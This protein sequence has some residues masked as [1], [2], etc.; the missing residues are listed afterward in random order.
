MRELC[1]TSGEMEFDGLLTGLTPANQ[2]S[3]GTIA[4]TG[5]E[6]TYVRGTV[7]AKSSNDNMLYI[8]GTEPAEDDD[9]DPIE[10]LTPD[11]ILCD[12]ITVGA[13]GDETVAVYTAGCFDPNKVTL[14][15]SYDMTESDK[16]ELRMRN[17]VFKAATK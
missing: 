13:S 16:D 11:C 5:T 17:I 2:V 6:T 12:D 4:A 8:L 7:F 1:N 10:T 15:A 3:G 14:A 9:G